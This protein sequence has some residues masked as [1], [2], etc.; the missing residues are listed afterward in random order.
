MEIDVAVRD[1]QEIVLFE[2]KAKALTS[3]SRTG[4]MMVFINDYTKSFLA[5]LR[6]LMRHDRNIKQGLTPLTRTDDDPTA[7]RITEIAVSPLSYG[8]ASDHVLTNALMRPFVFD[9]VKRARLD[10]VTGCDSDLAY[11]S[12]RRLSVQGP[13]VTASRDGA[14]YRVTLLWVVLSTGILQD[15]AARVEPFPQGPEH[16]EQNRRVDATVPGRGGPGAQHLPA[17]CCPAI[18]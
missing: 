3:K 10:Q 18:S 13:I 7:P 6:Q 9:N 15:V 14:G 16:A 5:L 4:D 11:W 1:G 17:T 12:P 8:P 2:T